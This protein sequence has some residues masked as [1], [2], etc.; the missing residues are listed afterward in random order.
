[1]CTSGKALTRTTFKSTQLI[2]LLHYYD[3]V[4]ASGLCKVSRSFYAVVSLIR[5]RSDRPCTS[6]N[7]IIAFQVE[8]LLK[9]FKTQLFHYTPLGYDK[10]VF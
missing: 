9:Q 5:S 4:W 1:V 7:P 6:S 2:F 8:G 10:N 3:A